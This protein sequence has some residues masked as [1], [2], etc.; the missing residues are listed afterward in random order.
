VAKWSKADKRTGAIGLFFLGVAVI[1]L[2]YEAFLGNVSIAASGLTAVEA[3]L[4]G[5]FAVVGGLYL[6]A[7]SP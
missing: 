2:A 4:L 1:G 7:V 6:L 5:F 3:G